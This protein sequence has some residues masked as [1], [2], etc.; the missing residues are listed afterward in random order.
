MIADRQAA[1]DVL[2]GGGL[3]GAGALLLAL[4]FRRS[5]V[6]AIWVSAQGLYLPRAGGIRWSE[7]RGLVVS[8]AG[9]P[10]FFV[11]PHDPNYRPRL[12]FVRELN[13]RLNSLVAGYP[14]WGAIPLSGVA[15]DHL[16][17]VETLL[18]ATGVEPIEPKKNL[19]RRILSF[20][21]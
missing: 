2:F 9:L 4:T 6:P 19:L 13:R 18:D 15:S 20:L 7:V 10:G 17:Y 16:D 5:K 12:N 1:E 3:L 8:T 21:T 11:V 14:V